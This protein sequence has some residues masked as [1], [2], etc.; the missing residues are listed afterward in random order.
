MHP[1][2]PWMMHVNA[3]E[4]QRDVERQLRLREA[5]NAARRHS[6][7]FLGGARRS[8]GLALIAAGSRIQPEPRASR[9]H[10]PSLELEL[11]R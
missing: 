6:F 1:Q 10:D 9:D 8:L 2:H 5:R 11:A 4:M 7:G 3:E